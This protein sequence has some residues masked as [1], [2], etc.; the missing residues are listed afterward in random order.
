LP[1]L[2]ANLE[3]IKPIKTSSQK[4]QKQAKA[5]KIPTDHSTTV[6]SALNVKR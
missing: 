2:P 4:P 1:D 3:E 6:G 5:T